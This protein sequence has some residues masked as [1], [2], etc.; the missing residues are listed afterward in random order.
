[1]KEWMLHGRKMQSL[2]WQE[3]Y[4]WMRDKTLYHTQTYWKMK[5]TGDNWT[6]GKPKLRD[7]PHPYI[8]YT[9]FVLP[10]GI[11]L[12]LY[13]GRG[14]GKDCLS[15]VTDGGKSYFECEGYCTVSWNS[16]TKRVLLIYKR[17]PL[18]QTTGV[19]KAVE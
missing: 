12:R 8:P 13:G 14:Y 1:M 2:T 10:D 5:W 19:L 11:V 16:R 17:E 3:F 18:A 6:S 15:T 4:D 7:D 9:A